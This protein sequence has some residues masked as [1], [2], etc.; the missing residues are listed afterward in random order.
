[1]KY[2]QNIHISRVSYGKQNQRNRKLQMEYHV[3]TTEMT[4]YITKLEKKDIIL[5]E[6]TVKS[7]STKR[8]KTS[9]HPEYIGKE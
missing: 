7:S 4:T 6:N 9:K 1:M 3:N 5:R 2:F 8:L